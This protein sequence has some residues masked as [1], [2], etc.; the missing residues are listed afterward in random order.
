MRVIVAYDVSQDARRARLAA[1]LSCWGDRIQRSVFECQLDQLEL[2]EVLRRAS[3]IID[4]RTDV[5]HAFPHCGS[6]AGGRAELGQA[7]RLEDVPYWIV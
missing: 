4:S 1:L 7:R 5:V 2:V 6:C 3:V